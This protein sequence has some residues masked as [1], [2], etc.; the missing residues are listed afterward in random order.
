MLQKRLCM[1][2]MLWMAVNFFLPLF[3]AQLPLA[4]GYISTI[5]P[6]LM[7]KRLLPLAAYLEKKL[8]RKIVL[9]TGADYRRT[10]QSFIDGTYDFGWIGPSP[11]V[12]ATKRAPG[13]LKILGAIAGEQG[14]SMVGAIVVRKDSPIHS[15]KQLEGKRF[16]FGSPNSTLSYYVPK[17]MLIAQGVE[18]QLGA[19]AFLGRHDRVAKYVIMGRYD[20][21]ALK[22][23]VA[24]E[25]GHF[26]R[27]LSRSEPIPG[28]AFVASS[29]MAEP[30]FEE[31]RAALLEISDPSILAP[32]QEDALKVVKRDDGDYDALRAMMSS[33]DQGRLNNRYHKNVIL[34]KFY[35]D[36]MDS[37]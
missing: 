21:G 30:L 25:Y 26:L 31:I 7:Q 13:S 8:K 28:F 23:S 19:Y 14:D 29:K 34:L 16:A 37:I 9:Q 15:M 22:A 35:A 3:A 6:S 20:A 27:I 2:F 5:D 10:I 11:Y 12:N 36:A 18:R 32:L 1:A 33:V 24:K 4:F 17:A